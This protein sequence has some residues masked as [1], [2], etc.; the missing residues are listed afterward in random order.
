MVSSSSGISGV[1]SSQFGDF[2]RQPRNEYVALRS[3]L[4]DV[5]ERAALSMV[6]TLLG[7]SDALTTSERRQGFAQAIA[8]MPDIHALNDQEHPLIKAIV[9]GDTELVRILL[10]SVTLLRLK[11][12]VEFLL[13]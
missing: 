11:P 10:E 2:A 7:F 3:P 9:L 4:S 12:L 8:A 5:R 13:K 1:N 6:G